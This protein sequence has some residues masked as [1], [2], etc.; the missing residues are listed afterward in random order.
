MGTRQGRSG[1]K[2]TEQREMSAPHGGV[3]KGVSGEAWG[4]TRG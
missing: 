4:L 3:L 1:E 2:V